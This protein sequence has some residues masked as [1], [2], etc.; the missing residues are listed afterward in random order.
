MNT[1]A[2]ARGFSLV[3]LLLVVGIIG[4]I[5][6]LAI[7]LV[8]NWMNYYTLQ[9]GR[10]AVAGEFQE[11]RIQAIMKNANKGVTLFV[12]D[13]NSYRFVNNDTS[14][15]GPLRDLPNGVVFD[16]TGLTGGAST[17][18]LRFSR[19]GAACAQG[20]GTCPVDP[21]LICPEHGCNDVPSGLAQMVVD[22]AGPPAGVM[23]LRLLDTR[24]N[25]EAVLD[26][27]QGGR[28]R[29]QER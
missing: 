8:V 3:E 2:R 18:G 20:V 16:S 7:P 1:Q 12:V 6:A 9:S 27:D 11:A 17:N 26:I 10:R 25:L 29:E 22:A 19:L 5:S 28:I 4:A 15:A 14:V 24:R 13:A 21:P 23:R